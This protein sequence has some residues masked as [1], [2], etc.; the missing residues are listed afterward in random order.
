MTQDA[1]AFYSKEISTVEDMV[2]IQGGCDVWK[3]RTVWMWT[4][5]CASGY[6]IS[7]CISPLNHV[8]WILFFRNWES[9][10]RN[11]YKRLPTYPHLQQLLSTYHYQDWAETFWHRWHKLSIPTLQPPSSVMPALQGSPVIMTYIHDQR[12]S[13][14]ALG[15]SSELTF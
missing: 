5:T 1:P 2:I 7:S 15:L 6:R 8:F 12:G 4:D 13:W 11:I 10:E 14:W 3:Q 9:H